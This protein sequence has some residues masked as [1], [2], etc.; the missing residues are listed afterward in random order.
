MWGWEN[1][2]LNAVDRVTVRDRLLEV[3]RDQSLRRELGWET[4]LDFIGDL[5]SHPLH[6]LFGVIFDYQIPY[7]KAWRAPFVLEERLVERGI[8]FSAESIAKMSEEELAEILKRK[9][10][11]HRFPGKV[12]KALIEAAKRVNTKYNSDPLS[13][14]SDKPTA[15]QLEERFD[16]FWGIG[17]KNASMAVRL[18]VEWFNVEVS[19]D[20]SGID[21]SG[22]RNVLRVFKRLGLIDKEEVGKAIQ[23]ARGLNPSYPGALDFPAWAIG[24]KWCKPKNP[25]CPS[26][27]LGDICPKLL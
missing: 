10:A 24:I 12:S 21:V 9:P 16:D 6:F 1:R 27:P 26:C 19:G 8:K 11:L 5:G 2:G 25:E 15:K 20:R 3:G 7:E 23:I 18:L 22:D 17:Q 14:W 4:A 13:I